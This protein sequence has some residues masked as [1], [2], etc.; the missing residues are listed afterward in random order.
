MERRRQPGA[1]R[2]GCWAPALPLP[3]ATCAL[4]RPPNQC[5]LCLP[6]PALGRCLSLTQPGP[7][8]RAGET[9]MGMERAR[10]W[11]SRSSHSPGEGL[12]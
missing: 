8:L 5:G 6:P 2:G 1:G 4:G 11:L 12:Q 3:W 9:Q 7:G 10:S